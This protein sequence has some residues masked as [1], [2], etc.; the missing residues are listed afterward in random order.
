MSVNSLKY[1]C[2]T[3]NSKLQ[4]QNVFEQKGIE[5][6]GLRSPELLRYMPSHEPEIVFASTATLPNRLCSSTYTEEYETVFRGF[7]RLRFFS[8]RRLK[9]SVSTVEVEERFFAHT[10]I[11]GRGSP[12]KRAGND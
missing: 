4:A 6:P 3:K 1:T 2:W 7:R 11:C 12:N 9:K 5:F 10:N 8:A